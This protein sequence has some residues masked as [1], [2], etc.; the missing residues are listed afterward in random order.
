MPINGRAPGGS[1]RRMADA[2]RIDSSVGGR[3]ELGHI[4]VSK[5]RR[6]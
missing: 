2:L 4:P 1:A 3:R 5:I 6:P